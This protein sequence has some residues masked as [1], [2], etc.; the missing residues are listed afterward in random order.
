MTNNKKSNNS[1]FLYTALIFISAIIIII[2]AAFAQTN[3]EMA[4]PSSVPGN[5]EEQTPNPSEG[6]QGIA[7]SASQLS[8]DNLDLLE[9]NR[10]L[11]KQL[12]EL[13][14]ENKNYKLLLDAYADYNNG[15]NE[16]SKNTL[17]NIQYEELTPDAKT[18]YDFILSNI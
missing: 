8:Q 6:P 11:N 13:E 12:N 1:L 2:F 4:Q 9:E 17:S 14:K 10:E 15:N 5:T 18:L 7:K 3:V 16:G